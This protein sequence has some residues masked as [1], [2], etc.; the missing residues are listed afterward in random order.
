M[1]NPLLNR[2]LVRQRRLPL[3]LAILA[4]STTSFFS[5]PQ[6]LSASCDDYH[7][8]PPFLS[9][10][11]K[12]N[13]MFMLDNSGSMKN[14]LGSTTGY[15]C[16]STDTAFASATTYYGMFDSTKTYSYDDTIPVDPTPFSGAAGM[17]Y[18]V[19][20]D[21]TATGTFISFLIPCEKITT[22]A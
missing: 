8:V 14:P 15:E 1:Q 11:L 9:S 20:V 12:P 10:K 4:F 5:S 2:S 13:V 22:F 21:T 19:T 6:L 16:G 18:N 17:P 3:V 7:A